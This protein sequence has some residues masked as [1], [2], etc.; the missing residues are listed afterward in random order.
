[1][2]SAAT[3]T[4]AARPTASAP[5]SLLDGRVTVRRVISAELIKV[6]SLRSMV[7]AAVIAALSIVAGGVFAAIGIIVS[8]SS[9]DGGTVATLTRPAVP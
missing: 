2:T 1:M 8:K 9:P 7:I 3:D 5:P 6:R 4:I